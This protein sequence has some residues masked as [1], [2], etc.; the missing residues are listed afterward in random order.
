MNAPRASRRGF[1]LLPVVVTLL[2]VGVIAL[3]LNLQA[4]GGLERVVADAEGRSADRV[5]EG[6]LTHATWLLH[7]QASCSGYGPVAGTLGGHTY[8]VA[9]T[10]ASG[11]PVALT[12]N[13]VL[14][15]GTAREAVRTGVAVFD[16]TAHTLTLQPGPSAGR[17][18]TIDGN[19]PGDNFGA[20]PSLEAEYG[21]FRRAVIDFDLASV[22]DAVRIDSAVLELHATGGNDQHEV[23]VSPLEHAWDEGSCADGSCSPSDGVTWSTRDGSMAWDTA[24]GDFVTAAGVEGNDDDAPWIRFDVTTT[25]REWR[26]GQ[27]AQHGFALVGPVGKRATF[28]SSDAADASRHPRLVVSYRCECGIDCA[29]AQPVAQCDAEFVPDL[30]LARYAVDGFGLS[31]VI[32]A[33][34]VPAG[35][36]YAGV[37]LAEP[38]GLLLADFSAGVIALADRGGSV[39]AK[40]AALDAYPRGVAWL[41]EAGGTARVAVAHY[42]ARMIVLHDA[43]GTAV[44]KLDTSGY[45]S[46]PEGLALIGASASGKFDG[47]LAVASPRDRNGSAVG[48]VYIVALD[49]TLVHTVDVAALGTWINGVAHLPGSDKLLI[50]DRYEGAFI[51]DFDGNLA[52]SYP[53]AGFGM[54]ANAESTIDSATC[55][56]IL[57]DW[58]SRTT[59]VLTS[60]GAGLVAHW[61]LDEA[62]GEVAADAVGTNDGVVSVADW[63]PGADGNGLR[64]SGSDVRV[65]DADALDLSG[66]FTLALWFRYDGSDGVLLSKGRSASDTNYHLEVTGSDALF[67]FS[68]SGS[69]ETFTIPLGTLDKESWHHLVVSYDD[70]ADAVVGY[71]DGGVALSASTTARPAQNA[72]EL[73]LG[74]S[75][76]DGDPWSGVLD[77]VRLYGKALDGTTVSALFDTFTPPSGSCAGTYADDFDT[78]GFGGST[79]TLAWSGPWQEW[80]ESDGPSSGDIAVRDSG[81]NGWLR[82]Q[83]NDGGGEGAGRRLDLTGVVKAM[84]TLTYRRTGLDTSSDYVALYVGEPSTIT[85]SEVARISGPGSDST[86]QTLS[87]DISAQAG[88]PAALLLLGS[89]TLGYNDAVYFDRVTVEVSGCP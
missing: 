18:A 22:P 47:H 87:V 65:A 68:S 69:L 42:Y 79:G 19:R 67:A 8:S 32:S 84:V 64:L 20:S 63:V 30:E 39:L 25:V 14:A 4:A 13:A 78:L 29:P 58:G 45:T 37:T 48:A 5:L 10:P 82:V 71:V 38:G 23:R 85:S 31:S 60:G 36:T 7:K 9:V 2:L 40:H 12:A 33:E 17:D 26:A 54:S 15:S 27:R 55:H 66:A 24:G 72:R 11:S 89:S 53:T 77:D 43:A 49:G 21:A 70:T 35:E 76:R 83:D 56:H 59:Y 73:R 34:H 86:L 57:T 41:G 52:A 46:A 61:L 81:G 28:A 6:A 75:E 62:N 50:T 88:A 80:N 74:S 51:V 16:G 3:L 1:V 44:A